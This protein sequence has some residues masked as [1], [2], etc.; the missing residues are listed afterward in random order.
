MSATHH[1]NIKQAILDPA[2]V[3]KTP[4]EVVE[5]KELSRG[6]KIKILHQWEYDERELEVAEEEN[7]PGTKADVLDLVLQALNELEDEHTHEHSAPT[8]QGG[9]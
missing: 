6:Q 4:H 2:S 5:T 8:K 7:M 3:F 9:E 1:I